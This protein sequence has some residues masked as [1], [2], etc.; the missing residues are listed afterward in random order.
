MESTT[1][2][3]FNLG[4]E[5]APSS[6]ARRMATL[7]VHV[8]ALPGQGRSHHYQFDPEKGFFHFELGGSK[9]PLLPVLRA[10]GVNDKQL[11]STWGDDIF[12]ANAVAKE[13]NAIGKMY[14]KLVRKP[15]ATATGED[16]SKAVVADLTGTKLDPEVTAITLGHPHDHLGPE[17][18][19][20]STKRLLEVSRNRA[21]AGRP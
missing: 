5:P 3:G 19:L 2:L 21:R 15:S 14:Q 17:A 8:N 12:G 1:P 4:S 16:Q 11:R 13:G 18:I 20:E 6:A 9:V 10:M 7:H